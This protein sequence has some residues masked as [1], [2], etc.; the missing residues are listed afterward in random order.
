MIQ[1]DLNTDGKTIQWDSSFPTTRFMWSKHKLLDFIWDN[2]KHL[3]FNTVLDAFS[4]SWCVWYMLKTK[5]KEVYSNDLLQYSYNI[6]KASIEN[7]SEKL[8][9]KDV[10]N[11]L[12]TETSTDWFIRNTFKDL[13]FT[14]EE[15]IFLEKVWHNINDLD[16]DYKKSI[17]ISAL[18]RACVKKRPRGIFTYVWSRYNDWRKDLT[19]SIED[20]FKNAV[21]AFNKSIFN[22]NKPNSSTHWNIFNIQKTD[23]D[24][25]YI[26]PPYYSTRSD[27]DYLRRYHFVEWLCSYWKDVEIQHSTKTK[28]I[29]KMNT[30]FWSRNEIY[31]SFHKLF[32]KFPKSIFVVS[33]SSNSLP[34]KEEMIEILKLFRWTVEVKELDYKYSIW[35]HNHKIGNNKNDVKEYLFIA[36]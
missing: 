8:S 11:L 20:Q 10:D 29:K 30:R 1:V 7:N 24:L 28:K 2:I 25:I 36:Y 18:C 5:W 33:Y 34:N 16:N 15:Y 22:N 31:E 26:D 35:N 21:R 6:A 4:W 14:D 19:T 23:Y 13:Y 32:E 27:N 3:D 12:W 9:V 17:A